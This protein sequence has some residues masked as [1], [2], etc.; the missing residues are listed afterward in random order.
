MFRKILVIGA[1]VLAAGGA[2]LAAPAGAQEY[3][4]CNLTASDITPTAGQTVTVSGTGA[5]A[6]AALTASIDGTAIGTGTASATG[7]Y[8]FSATI[9]AGAAPG[10]YTVTIN[11][12]AADSGIAVLDIT[13][14]AGSTTLPRT[15]TDGAL[16]MTAVALAS[17]A[18][19]GV[20]LAAAKVRRSTASGNIS[21]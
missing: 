6:G 10:A 1:V 13:V 19:G 15:G 3:G 5:D 20:A 21:L 14:V 8:S 4:G 18:L 9:P 11:C 12:G 2:A 7:D 16:P 17:L